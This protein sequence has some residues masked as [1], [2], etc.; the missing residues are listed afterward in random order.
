MNTTSFIFKFLFFKQLFFEQIIQAHGENEKDKI[1]YTEKSVSCL[2]FVSQSPSLEVITY[3]QLLIYSS[4]DILYKNKH[5]YMLTQKACA[6][7]IL[8]CLTKLPS[9]EEVPIFA[10]IL[11]CMG[12]PISLYFIIKLFY[13]YQSGR[14]KM[15]HNRSFNLYFS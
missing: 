12:V 5:L 1:V 14:W 9:I 13:L 11:S 2:F 4:R 8:I 7:K 6:L 15:V 3:Y 10:P